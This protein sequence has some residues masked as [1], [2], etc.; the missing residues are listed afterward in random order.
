MDKIKTYFTEFLLLPHDFEEAQK[1]AVK[2]RVEWKG[3]PYFL[4]PQMSAKEMKSIFL[5]PLIYRFHKELG[6]FSDLFSQSR[7]LIFEILSTPRENFVEVYETECLK[8]FITDFKNCQELD[9]QEM[10]KELCF[11]YYNLLEFKNYIFENFQETHDLEKYL[12]PYFKIL[13]MTLEDIQ[14]FLEE[15]ENKKRNVIME[16]LDKAFWDL[17]KEKV[18]RAELEMVQ[19]CL[20]EIRSLLL[21]VC[22]PRFHDHLNDILDIEFLMQSNLTVETIKNLS[23]EVVNILCQSDSE[24]MEGIYNQVL[25]EIK[26]ENHIVPMMKHIYTL[27][28]FL[29]I[30]TE[31]ILSTNSNRIKE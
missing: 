4:Y 15:I 18:D 9:R 8:T 1:L 3:C 30:R 27:V 10:G 6:I 25:E 2:H 13:G 31:I 16:M 26:N 19:S 20:F 7:N 14:P 11:H 23:L 24:S 21:K 12:E 17:M 28:L 22:H 29:E 5:C